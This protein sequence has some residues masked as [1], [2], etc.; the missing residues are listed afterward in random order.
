MSVKTMIS[1][2]HQKYSFEAHNLQCCRAITIARGETAACYDLSYAKLPKYGHLLRRHNPSTMFKLVPY[3]RHDFT[4]NPQFKRLF[5]CLQACKNWFLDRCR[6]FIGL[7]ECHLKGRYGGVLLSAISVDGNNGI[8]PVA[9]GIVEVEN[10]DSWVFFFHCLESTL[11]LDYLDI[12]LTFMSDKQKGH[13]DVIA[14]IVLGAHH[15]N[16][17]RHL[18]SNFKAS[19]PGLLLKTQFWIACKEP[20]EFIYNKAI[21]RIKEVNK[22]AYDWLVKNNQPSMWCRHAFDKRAKS[23]HVTNNMTESFNNWNGELRSKPILI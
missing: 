23:D 2:L 4:K 1:V 8:Y 13:A 14:G 16:C 19:F 7:D 20:N 18:Y 15:R 5:V 11:R 6:P 9:F 22:E 21:E 17:C 12:G 3:E 10:K